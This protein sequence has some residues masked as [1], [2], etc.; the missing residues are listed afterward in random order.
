[1]RSHRLKEFRI[2]LNLIRDGVTK[3]EIVGSYEEIHRED[4]VVFN[5]PLQV[6][7]KITKVGEDFLLD[8]EVKSKGKFV[9]DRCREYFK[10]AVTGRVQ[11]LFTFNSDKDWQKTDTDIKLLK[12]H[13][14]EIDLAEDIHDA[15][16]LT[17]PQKILCNDACLGLCPI[18]GINLNTSDCQCSKTEIDS[19]WNGLKN[20]KFD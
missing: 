18:C 11:S 20:I 6:D 14:K 4:V 13:T 17:I 3:F 8:L 12:G 10:K 9:C 15:L 7:A 1:M 2:P 19:R 16:L 5:N